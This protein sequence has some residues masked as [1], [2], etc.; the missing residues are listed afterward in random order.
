M[1]IVLTGPLDD[2]LMLRCV[3]VCVC[4]RARACVCVRALVYS[5]STPHHPPSPRSASKTFSLDL[6]RGAIRLEYALTRDGSAT[7]ATYASPIAPWEVTRVGPNG[8]TFW[9]TDNSASPT[10]GLASSTTDLNGATW[11]EHSS[12]ATGDKLLTE[13]CNGWVA[14]AIDG[15]SLLVKR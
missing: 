6:E 8:I 10:G 1:T 13:G 2:D 11:Y 12:T 3:C 7:S 4:V 5:H 14:Q 9:P 15:Q